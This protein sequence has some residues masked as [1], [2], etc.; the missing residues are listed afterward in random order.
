MLPNGKTNSQAKSNMS[1]SAI[2]LFLSR[3]VKKKNS[4]KQRP[5]GKQIKTIEQHILK[6]LDS[7]DEARAKVATVSWLILVPNMRVGDE[8]DPDEADTVGAITL[9]AEHIKYSKANA[10]PF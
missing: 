4:K 1:G 9:R 10:N 5:L 6:N 2:Q 7:K 3:T 8:K